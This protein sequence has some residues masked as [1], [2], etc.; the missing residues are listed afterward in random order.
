MSIVN[1]FKDIRSRMQGELKAQPVKV[2]AK[3]CPTCGG[4]GWHY[5]P[6][7]DKMICCPTCNKS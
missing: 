2:G 5:H 6:G 1:N 3:H 7:S 4:S